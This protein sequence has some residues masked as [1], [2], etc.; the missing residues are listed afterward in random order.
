[1]WSNI[2][3]VFKIQSYFL[4]VTC[5]NFIK[6][7]FLYKLHKNSALQKLI[8]KYAEVSKTNRFRI[9]I[10][11]EITYKQNV[12][13]CHNNDKELKFNGITFTYIYILKG[14]HICECTCVCHNMH[15]GG[16]SRSFT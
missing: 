11:T 4:Y 16:P 3:F 13:I 5:H 7:S 14:I 1:M 10:N 9:N 8:L 15:I 6:F 2:C 12:F